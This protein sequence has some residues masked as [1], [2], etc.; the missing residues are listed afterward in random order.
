MQ[1]KEVQQ[2]WETASNQSVT[3]G[4][5]GGGGK[6]KVTASDLNPGTSYCIRLVVVGAGGAK[7]EPGPELII[8]TEQVGCTPKSSSGGC[9]IL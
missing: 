5:G 9:L 6:T 3:G 1:W 8:D 2:P 4:S 7:G